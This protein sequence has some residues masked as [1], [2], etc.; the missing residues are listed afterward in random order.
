MIGSGRSGGGG[1]GEVKGSIGRSNTTAGMS[2]AGSTLVL[3]PPLPLPL[4]TVTDV[5]AFDA[6]MKRCTAGEGSSV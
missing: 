1:G 5:T 4:A 6:A 3:P 2:G